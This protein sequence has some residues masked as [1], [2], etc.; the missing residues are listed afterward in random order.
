VLLLALVLQEQEEQLVL[1]L[2]VDLILVLLQL[3]GVSVLMDLLQ[4]L[5][6]LL[7]VEQ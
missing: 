7:L 6:E 3:V 2:L 4:Q 5:V 1:G